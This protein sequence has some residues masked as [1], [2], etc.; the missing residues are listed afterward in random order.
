MSTVN[1]MRTNPSTKLFGFGPM[2]AIRRYV[3]FG[4][5][6][7]RSRQTPRGPTLCTPR[8][9]ELQLSLARC[10]RNKPLMLAAGYLVVS[11]GKQK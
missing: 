7:S 3:S 6:L 2:L 10:I 9:L 5:A 11:V 8:W 1:T 4:R